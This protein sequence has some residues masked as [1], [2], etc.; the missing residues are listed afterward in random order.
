MKT[1]PLTTHPLAVGMQEGFRT[2][3]EAHL[4][5]DKLPNKYEFAFKYIVTVDTGE[6]IAVILVPCNP[7]QYKK[8]YVFGEVF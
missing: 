4:A 5:W 8:H 7:N 1:A 6:T 2:E 3:E